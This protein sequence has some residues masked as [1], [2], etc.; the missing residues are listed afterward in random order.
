MTMET[1]LHYQSLAHVEADAVA[2]VLFEEETAPAELKFAAAWLDELKTSGE[3]LGK[4]GDLAVLHQ[5][6]GIKAK[7]LVVVGGGKKE[8]F[9]SPALRKAA[10]STV[11]TLK[12]KGV[13]S[14][15]WLLEGR[16]AEAAVEGA[17]LGNFEPEQHKTTTDAKSLAAF[18]VVAAANGAE[19]EKSF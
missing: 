14:L 4:T 3:F 10:G 13:K 19:I 6:Q 11:R 2:L 5:P 12:Q 17:L 18:Q 7:R 15:A 16:D 8:K 9:D 1:K